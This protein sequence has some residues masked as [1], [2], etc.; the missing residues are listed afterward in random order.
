MGPSSSRD[1]NKNGQ[2]RRGGT[3][4]AT[5]TSRS[6]G[7]IIQAPLIKTTATPRGAGSLT[8]GLALLRG[9]G[10]TAPSS[11]AEQGRSF[12]GGAERPTRRSPLSTPMSSVRA[13]A[14]AV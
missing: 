5:A 11:N 9:V 2:P 8:L 1:A 10:T 4:E 12:D 7:S 13:A 6:S 14:L 3:G